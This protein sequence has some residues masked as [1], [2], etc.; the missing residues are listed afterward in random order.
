MHKNNTLYMQNL[1]GF[2]IIDINTGCIIDEIKLPETK[3][4]NSWLS[5]DGKCIFIQTYRKYKLNFYNIE[6]ASYS[7]FAVW[8]MGYI[9]CASH[10]KNAY[11][12]Y[13]RDDCI[14][15]QDDFTYNLYVNGKLTH[16]IDS[17]L[18]PKIIGNY[19]YYLDYGKYLNLHRINIDTGKHAIFPHDK[20][21]DSG[22]VDYEIVNDIMIFRNGRYITCY[23]VNS[24]KHIYT[25]N[26]VIASNVKYVATST[27]PNHYNIYN[28]ETGKFIKDLT[29]PNIYHCKI[30]NDIFMGIIE[31]DEIHE[32]TDLYSNRNYKD[33]DAYVHNIVTSET[34][35][36][37]PDLPA[38]AFKNYSNFSNNMR[39][40]VTT[41]FEN[42]T[43][44]FT[45]V[46]N[47][48]NNDRK[49]AFLLGKNSPESSIA[50]AAADPLF[51]E[52]LFGEIF[53]MLKNS[54]EISD[55]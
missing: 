14:N 7:Y 8:N 31:N 30:D 46:T 4:R 39:Y 26:D 12:L 49:I 55:S 29:T 11:V 40:L 9:R 47:L 34:A 21:G 17:M 6:T 41:V 20:Y 35:Y 44:N 22:Y 25:L 36:I 2:T 5:S 53:T 10:E 15:S 16:N 52:H 50:R 51:D 18:I 3:I 23:E 32:H 43:L 19:L 42:A 48:F 38:Y 1:D 54:L 13:E 45:P 37:H 24:T 27:Q 33:Y 28:V